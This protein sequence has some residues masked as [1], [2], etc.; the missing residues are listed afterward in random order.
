MRQTVLIA[1]G[2]GELCELYRRFLTD[3]GYEVETSSDGLDCMRMLRQLAPAA[4]VLDLELHWGGG[5]GVL[6]CMRE[7]NPTRGI[8][9]ILTATAACDHDSAEIIEVPVVDYLPKP[10]ALSALLEKI[11]SA[12]AETGRREPS[13]QHRA[14]SYSELFIG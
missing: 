14:S 1:D 11:R 9:V 8:P 3:R 5:D 6:G 4:L 12:I 7:E 2:D 10:F 13:K